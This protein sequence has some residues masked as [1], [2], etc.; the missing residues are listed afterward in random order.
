MKNSRL[1]LDIMLLI[2][3]LLAL[4]LYI[5]NQDATWVQSISIILIIST[6]PSLLLLIYE[7]VKSLLNHK[8]GVDLLA[9]LSMS[10]ALWMNEPATAAVIA[11]MTASGRFLE[12]YARG[13][14]EREMV[15]LLSRVP[16]VANRL[17][18][19]G[20]QVIPVESI[21]PGYLLLVKLGET[22]PVDGPLVSVSA[23]LNE[24]SITGESLPVTRQTGELLLSGTIN[25]GDALK[26]H[27]AR[28]AKDST[29]Q[30]IIS[31]VEQAGQARAPAARLADRYAVWFIPFTLI[32][33]W[34]AWLVSQDPIRALAVLVV[35]TPCP[36]AG[37]AGGT[38][39]RDF[40]LCKAGNFDQR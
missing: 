20:I 27:A 23:V 40:S 38:G 32:V 4:M 8:F 12:N 25:A 22:I 33:A 30:G 24:S 17:T 2:F 26:M 3:P 14:A 34:L 29:L 5:F 37:C 7:V 31:V 39:I 6:I 28:A 13:R 21:Q 11:A 9:I 16:R 18:E 10:G 35:A 19:D 1:L 15:A 36:P